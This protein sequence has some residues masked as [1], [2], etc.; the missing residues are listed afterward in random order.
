LGSAQLATWL[1][2]V[3]ALAC[4]V[5]TFL[6]QGE[7]P[8]EYLK[9]LGSTWGGLVLRLGLHQ[10]YTS[11][12]FLAI[13]ALLCLNLAVSIQRRVARLRR[14][15]AAVKV[16]VP[17]EGLARIGQRLRLKEGLPQA[18][19]RVEAA[20]RGLGMRWRQAR[21][22]ATVYYYAERGGWRRWGSTWAHLGFLLVFLGALVGR[23]PGLGYQGYLYA[24]QGQVAAVT[25]GEEGPQT[26]MRLRIHRFTVLADDEGRPRDF[27]CDVELLDG[28]RSV[29]RKTIRVNDPLVYGLVTFY[30]SG[31]GL[32]GFRLALTG[33]GKDPHK[34][35]E[36]PTGPKGELSMQDSVLRTPRGSFLLVSRFYPH[37]RPTSGEPEPVSTMPVAPAAEIYEMGGDGQARS[38]GWLMPGQSLRAS[39]GTTVELAGLVVYTGIQYRRDPGYPLVAAGFVVSTAG[40]FLSFYLA[41]RRLRVALVESPQGTLCY[42]AGVPGPAGSE[43]GELPQKLADCLTQPDP[44]PAPGRTR[45]TSHAPA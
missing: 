31:Y 40:L 2:L 1:L 21:S 28:S 10:M 39:D 22:E 36:I 25:A 33:T 38:L 6:P 20:L 15:E 8:E 32:G 19:A 17:V 23:W 45:R 34:V 4:S 29:E 27:A 12:W 14:E 41:H 24:R 30:Q 11:P 26:G 18:A 37:A 13:L 35:V 3:L 42:I 44:S 43:P 16:A 5:G 9:T 7:K